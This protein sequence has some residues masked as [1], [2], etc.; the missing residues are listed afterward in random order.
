[1]PFAKPDLRSL[2]C[3]A[4]LLTLATLPQAHATTLETRTCSLL[5]TNGVVV[6]L[7]NRLCGETLVLGSG[8]ETGWSALHRLN[9]GDL[10]VEQAKRL[11][12]SNSPTRV[13]WTAEW[14]QAGA[15]AADRMRTWERGPASFP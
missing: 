5:M 3:V 10:R 12:M 9:Q 1:M 15:G 6:G 13:E 7:S 14:E 8:P 2:G 11:S 4:L